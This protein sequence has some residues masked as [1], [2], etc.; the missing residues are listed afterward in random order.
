VK[1]VYLGVD[2]GTCAV[3]CLAMDIHGNRLSHGEG[4][5]PLYAPKPGWVEQNPEEWIEP[6]YSA[7]RDC[8]KGLNNCKPIALSFSGHMSSLL[9]LDKDMK[10]LLPCSLVGDMRAANQANELNA[11]LCE[12]FVEMTGNVPWQAF[13]APKLLWIKQERPDV[14][15][16]IEKFVLAKDYIRYRMTDELCT[17]YTDAGNSLLFNPLKK[18]W[19]DLLITGSGLD[20]RIFPELKAP[21]EFA[22]SIN[23]YT[24]QVTGLPEG[25]PV[26]CGAADMACS[27]LGTGGLNPERLIITLSTSGQICMNV[28]QP[29]PMAKEKV[30]FHP[31][32]DSMY[33]MASV[34][35]GGLAVNWAYCLL[36][37]QNPGDV[38]DFNS[39]GVLAKNI[40]NFCPGKS[41]ITFLPFLTGSGSP[42]NKST[43]KAHFIGMTLASDRKDI[44]HAVMEGVAYNFRENADVFRALGNWSEVRLGG[45]GTKIKAWRH[46]IADVLGENIDILRTSDASAMGACMLAIAGV[47]HADSIIELSENFA[48]CDDRIEYNHKNKHEYD[49]LYEKY[50]YIYNSLE[51]SMQ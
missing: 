44:M 22:G 12:T 27:Q 15:E 36:S 41:G 20:K 49:E 46:I 19:D 51:H 45:G 28:K 35:S 34:F 39:L 4:R 30:T 18:D 50:C 37:G 33:A 32:I 23:S 24:S 31:G 16:Q 47:G 13:I 2:L 10:P 26:I 40:E 5:Y 3:K 1:H 7:I 25:L 21:T 43:D 29:S 11:K 8:L 42:H 38:P 17:D 9:V 6:V 48:I 14:Y